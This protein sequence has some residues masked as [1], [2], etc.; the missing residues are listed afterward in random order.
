MVGVIAV[1][2]VA[3]S[4]AQETNQFNFLDTRPV[5]ESAEDQKSVTSVYG[6]SEDDYLPAI[7]ELKRQAHPNVRSAGSRPTFDLPDAFYYIGGP[8][9]VLLLLR[10]LVIFLNGFEEKRREEQRRAE[11]QIPDSE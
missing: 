11:L 10:V 6:I 8:V 1:L 9:F 5:A 7:E 2:G 3:S 4:L